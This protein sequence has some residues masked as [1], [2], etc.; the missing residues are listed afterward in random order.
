ME[1]KSVG[2]WRHS[3]VNGKKH[4]PNHQPVFVWLIPKMLMVATLFAAQMSRK[5]TPESLAKWSPQLLQGNKN[6]MHGSFA[7]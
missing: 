5:K 7:S 2:I 4:D 3:Q 1:L 6:K